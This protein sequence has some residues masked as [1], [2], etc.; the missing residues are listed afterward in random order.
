MPGSSQNRNLCLNF[1]SH[2]VCCDHLLVHPGL[3]DVLQASGQHQTDCKRFF[4]AQV[5]LPVKY[6]GRFRGEIWY[7]V[8]YI[9]QQ[10]QSHQHTGLALEEAVGEGCWRDCSE[11]IHQECLQQLAQSWL[12]YLDWVANHGQ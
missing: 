6:Q 8:L 12:S 5:V 1:C 10:A 4:C 9:P 2:L 7:Q 11:N 3:P